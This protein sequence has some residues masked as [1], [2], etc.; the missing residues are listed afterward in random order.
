MRPTA[1]ALALFALSVPA[2]P[3]AATVFTGAVSSFFAFDTTRMKPAARARSGRI[4]TSDSGIFLAI[5]SGSSAAKMLRPADAIS[6][7][8]IHPYQ[9]IAGP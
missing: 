6:V 5:R 8:P 2:V 7:V 9:Y 4:Q 1:V 3:A